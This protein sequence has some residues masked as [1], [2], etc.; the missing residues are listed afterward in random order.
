MMVYVF[1]AV[2]RANYLPSFQSPTIIAGTYLPR[3]VV[4]IVVSSHVLCLSFLQKPCCYFTQPPLPPL[5]SLP[6]STLA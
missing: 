6:L 3:V 2:A 4:C 1:A 5:S